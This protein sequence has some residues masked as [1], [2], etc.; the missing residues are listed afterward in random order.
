MPLVPPVLVSLHLFFLIDINECLDGNGQCEHN[1]TNLEGT[2]S[3]SCKK[4]YYLYTGKGEVV[5][6][7][8]ANRSCLGIFLDISSFLFLLSFCGN[9]KQE[10]K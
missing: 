1:C 9:L 5:S 8:I 3:C 2:Y 6:E 10:G 4:G 7:A